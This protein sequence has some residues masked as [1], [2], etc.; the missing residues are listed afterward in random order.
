MTVR[1]TKSFPGA[2]AA[3]DAWKCARSPVAGIAGRIRSAKRAQVAR[4]TKS[5]ARPSISYRANKPPRDNIRGVHPHRTPAAAID[6]SQ[7]LP[8]VGKGECARRQRQVAAGSLTAANGL[9]P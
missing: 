1:I 9:R 8:H 2:L 3:A 4:S 6:R 5:E 7:Y